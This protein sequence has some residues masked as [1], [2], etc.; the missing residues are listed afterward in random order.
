MSQ[1]EDSEATLLGAE[2]PPETKI[3]DHL[4]LVAGMFEELEIGEGNLRFPASTSTSTRTSMS[5]R[6]RSARQ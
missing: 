4:G 3:L 5:G 2:K 1:S 6:S